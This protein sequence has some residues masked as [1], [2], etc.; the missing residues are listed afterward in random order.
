VFEFESGFTINGTINKY[1]KD[2]EIG[3]LSKQN[4]LAAYSKIDEDNTFSF[5]NVFVYKNENVKIALIQKNKPLVKP[6]QVSF[7]VNKP[8]KENYKDLI[9]PQ[10]NY[11]PK[12]TFQLKNDSDNSYNLGNEVEQLNAVIINNVKAKK[13]ETNFEKELNLAYDHNLISAGFYK[14]KKVTAQM[15]SSYQTLMAYLVQVGCSI[16]V[17]DSGNSMLILNSQIPTTFFG[18]NGTVGFIPAKIYINDAPIPSFG[19]EV[20]TDLQMYDVDEI[21]INKSG[22]GE[23]LTASG[24]VIK[25]YLKKG[26]HQYYDE[27]AKNLYQNLLVLTGYDR[28]ENYY[29]PIFNLTK[30]TFDWMEINWTNNLNTDVNGE[31]IIKVPTNKFSNNFKFIINGV[32]DNGLL[33]HDIYTENSN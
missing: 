9:N 7:I 10:S 12:T 1:P 11:N 14:S 21:L 28:A 6:N 30:T 3:M 24:G 8:L 23:G 18:A 5:K 33:F 27:P 31:L 4:R 26:G 29:K 2:Y 13:I 32:S 15:E 22:A 20:L 25:I 16:K 17:D 19:V